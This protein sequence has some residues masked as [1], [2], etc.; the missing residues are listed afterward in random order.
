MDQDTYEKRKK[1]HIEASK[2]AFE[3]MKNRQISKRSGYYLI[4]KSY[5]VRE[6][7]NKLSKHR[8]T[9]HEQAK[10]KVQHLA[11]KIGYK[12]YSEVIFV[13]NM[14]IADVYLPEILRVYELLGSETMAEYKKKIAKYPPELEIIPLKVEDVLKDDFCFSL[15]RK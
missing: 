6:G 10:G 15:S 4:D 12:A 7:H 2:R 11:M 1:R 14:G 13:N 9:D 5:N 3:R 8:S